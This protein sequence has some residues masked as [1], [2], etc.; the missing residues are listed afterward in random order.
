MT[1]TVRPHA[2]KKRVLKTKAERQREI[3]DVTIR[4]LAKYGLHGATISRISAA[5]GM[6]R[7]ALYYHFRNRE[8]LLAAAME[9]MDETATAW[10]AKPLGKD[11]PARLLAMGEAHSV[12]TLS[13]YN[14]FIRPF[15]QLIASSRETSLESLITTKTHFYLQYLVECVEEGQREGTIRGDVDSREVAWSLLLHAW[16]EDIARLQGIDEY[17]TE[18]VSRNILRRLLASYTVPCSCETGDGSGKEETQHSS[19]ESQGSQ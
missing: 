14:G 1:Q 4:I 12:W 17:I 10:I 18:G 13:A 6:S 16:G 7:G 8:E 5:A 3:L 15:Y 19:Q 2:K 11:A 9:A